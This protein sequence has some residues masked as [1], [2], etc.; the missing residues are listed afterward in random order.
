MK[1][2]SVLIAFSFLVP[3]LVGCSH[4]LYPTQERVV[5]TEKETKVEIIEKIKDTTIVISADSSLVE[6]LIE[7]NERGEAALK[8]VEQLRS[9]ERINQTL[10]IEDN[11]LTS[12]VVVDSMGIYLQYKERYER[13][14]VKEKEIVE[15]YIESPPEIVNVL[16]GWQKFLMWCG[17]AMIALI[18]LKIVIRLSSTKSNVVLTALK[19]ILKIN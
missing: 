3:L 9:S 13:E 12:K 1:P 10:K 2:N 6:A 8:E 16:K 14:E 11:R 15:V 5:E 18:I 7:C 19:G 4:R 17:V